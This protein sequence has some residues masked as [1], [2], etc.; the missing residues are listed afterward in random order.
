MRT[1]ERSQPLLDIVVQLLLQHAGF[2]VG[3]QTGAHAAAE[4]TALR[5]WHGRRRRDRFLREMRH[6]RFDMRR[7]RRPV[8][9][10]ARQIHRRGGTRRW[11]R[12]LRPKGKCRIRFRA[13]EWRCRLG[14]IRRSLRKHGRRMTTISIGC[15]D[16]SSVTITSCISAICVRRSGCMCRGRGGS[17]DAKRWHDQRRRGRQRMLLM[18]RL[19]V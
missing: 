5:Q 10:D 6:E 9:I 4:Q 11:L 3:I 7:R 16:F 14:A 19:L 15:N 12:R 2:R 1:A 8:S 13:S 18:L 17:R